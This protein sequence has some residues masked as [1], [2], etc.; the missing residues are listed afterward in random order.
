MRGDGRVFLRGRIWW[1]AYYVDGQE[2]RES[3]RSRDRKDAVRLLRRCLGD[4]AAGVLPARAAK[5]ARTRPVMMHD[6]FDL[7]EHNFRLNARTSPTNGACLRRMRKYFGGYTIQAC[8]GLAISHYMAARQRAGLKAATIN[9]EMCVLKVAFRLG[10][11]HDLVARMPVIKRMPE[12]GVRNEFFTRAE[13]DTLLPCLPD[14]LRD[15]VI[16]GFLT[17]WRKGEIV[18]LRWANINRAQAVIRLEPAQNKGR[19]VRVLVL[20]GELAPLIERRWE[21]RKAGR[22]LAQHVFH[23]GGRPLPDFHKAWLKACSRAGLGR[24]WFHSLRRSAARNMSLQ[25]IPEKV[26]MSIMGHKTRVMFDRYNIV[27]EAD[28]RAY[29]N[30]LFRGLNADNDADNERSDV[31]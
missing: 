23:R 19:T 7:V 29:G 6:L 4:V 11:E 15:V 21:A 8:T 25:G 26:I 31:P 30:R 20:Q 14:H 13:I 18:G 12:L 10:Y 1:I 16:F 22:T 24:R 17:G 9:R 5:R 28:Q 3:S 2:Y 27:T